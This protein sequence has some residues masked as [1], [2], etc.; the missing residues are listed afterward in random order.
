M[1]GIE[2]LSVATTVGAVATVEVGV[3]AVAVVCAVTGLVGEPVALLPIA[4]LVP[5]SKAVGLIALLYP[6][7][8]T[9]I[10]MINMATPMR[11]SGLEITPMTVDAMPAY[12]IA[13]RTGLFRFIVWSGLGGQNEAAVVAAADCARPGD[14]RPVRQ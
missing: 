5:Q 7:P 11:T 13:R 1:Y 9:I 2:T 6:P 8:P 10:T 14:A 4:E 12:R 3:D